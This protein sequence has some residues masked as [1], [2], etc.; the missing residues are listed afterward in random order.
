MLEE[1]EAVRGVAREGEEEEDFGEGR[2]GEGDEEGVEVE[3]LPFRFREVPGL[4]SVRGW[5]L[6][7]E[8]VGAEEAAEADGE[9]EDEGREMGGE[10]RH[11]LDRRR[12]SSLC[13]FNFS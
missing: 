8:R 5:V 4:G 9:E 13:F 1:G 6:Q 7:V 11:V 10:G 3:V 12:S 2:D